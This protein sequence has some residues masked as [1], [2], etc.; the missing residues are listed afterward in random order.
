MKYADALCF[1][2]KTHFVESRKAT[3]KYK[4]NKSKRLYFAHIHP[5]LSPDDKCAFLE[6]ADFSV[7]DD[8]NINKSMK[9][10]NNVFVQILD[11]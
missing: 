10:F 8:A 11:R 2:I 1:L 6:I 3:G 5:F 7:I 9:H 4:S